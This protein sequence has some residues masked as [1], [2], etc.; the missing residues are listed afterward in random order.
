M[1]SIHANSYDFIV[2]CKNL[3]LGESRPMHVPV[4]KYVHRE[5]KRVWYVDWESTLSKLALFKQLRSQPVDFLYLNSIFATFFS[6]LPLVAWKLGAIHPKSVVVAPR[7][8]LGIGA[9]ALKSRKKSIFLKTARLLKLHDG[10]H[11]HASS[12]NEATEILNLFPNAIVHVRENEVLLPPHPLEPAQE[13][14]SLTLRAVFVGR[15]SPKKGLH[16]LISAL[17]EQ[18]A[19]IHLD[20]YGEYEDASYRD[21]IS[22]QISLLPPNVSVLFHGALP[23]EHVR[24]AFQVSDVFFFP[25]AH[26]NFGHTIVES[27]SASCP[28]VICDVTP[29][30][31]VVLRGGGDIPPTNSIEDWQLAINAFAKTS[32][33]ERANRRT[34]AGEAYKNWHNSRNDES[35]FHLVQNSLRAD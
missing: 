34:M 28:V 25:T 15:L 6:I 17:R 27:L 32:P 3:D 10:V 8:E 5:G 19:L 23:H 18:D 24:A 4:D 21:Q 11:W 22:Q 30:T 26:E 13:C 35:V 7:G 33:E 2:Y 1:T 9:L 16:R 14:T 12:P 29:L 20:I 31:E